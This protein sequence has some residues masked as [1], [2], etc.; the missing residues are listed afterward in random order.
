MLAIA[1]WNKRPT[2]CHGETKTRHHE[3]IG[4]SAA[5]SANGP[6]PEARA[7]LA[8]KG[9]QV[10]ELTIRAGIKG[11]MQEMTLQVGQRVKPGDVLAKVAQPW[12]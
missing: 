5:R 6:D 7:T 9:R 4:R 12:N 11:R 1:K 2:F 8:L 10:G 3:A